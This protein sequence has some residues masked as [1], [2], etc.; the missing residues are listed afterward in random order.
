MDRDAATDLAAET[1]EQ[2]ML[3]GA[4]NNIEAVMANLENRSPQWSRA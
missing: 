4:A 2:G 3:L 1:A